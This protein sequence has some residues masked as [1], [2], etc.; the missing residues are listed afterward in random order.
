M[1]VDYSNYPPDWKTVI[2]PRIL[3]RAGNCCEWCHLPNYGIALSK[4]RTLLVDPQPYAQARENVGFYHEPGDRA[5]VVVLTIAH[6]DHDTANNK[7]DNLAALC[8]RCHL[9]HDAQLH[10][11]NARK[12][13]EARSGQLILL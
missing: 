8:Q 12:T 1:P 6:L 5:F 13:R 7:D 11:T 9:T 3:K 2:R 10:A 4:E